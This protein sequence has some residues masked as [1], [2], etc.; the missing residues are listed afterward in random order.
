LCVAVDE[1]VTKKRKSRKRK[2]NDASRQPGTA[3][4]ARS[5]EEGVE[6]QGEGGGEGSGE[7]GDDDMLGKR[8][9]EGGKPGAKK[10]RVHVIYFLYSYIF[11]YLFIYLFTSIYLFF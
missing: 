11:I 7:D 6:D 9:A 10:R 2:S 4:V 3:N 8:R 1:E 5:G